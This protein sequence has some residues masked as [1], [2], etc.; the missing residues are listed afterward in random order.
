MAGEDQEL[1]AEGERRIEWAARNMPV[2]AEIARRWRR[3]RPL[4]GVR[5]GACLHVTT[6][7]A[8]LVLALAGGGAS[9]ALCASNPLSTQDDVAAALNGRL[10]VPTFARRGEDQDTYYRH[11]LAVLDT[12]P[13]LV[14]DDGA[15][16][17]S[18]LHTQRAEL[19]DGVWA[20][21]EE[22]TTGVLRLAAMER[23]GSLR[24][25]VVAVNQAQTKHMFDNRYG[26]GQSA[27][28]GVLRATNRL[29]AGSTLVVVGY[30]WCGRGVAARGRGLGARVVVVEVDP[31]KALEAVMDGFWVTDM[32]EAARLGDL[33]ITVTGNARVI[34]RE[35]LELMKD[36]A[37]LANAG[38]F[39]VEVDIP[40]LQ[41]LA[42]SRRPARENVEEFTL[43][44]GRRLYL[45]GEGRLV[46]L[47]CAEGHPAQVMDMSFANQALTLEWLAKDRPPLERRVLPVPA[48]IDA[49]VARLKLESLGVRLEELTPEQRAYLSSWKLGTTG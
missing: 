15:D 11:I 2:L 31:L 23:E 30:G 36:G 46:N 1:V 33:F 25:P 43:A 35:H 12:R 22:T 38:H 9:V 39:N 14:M 49:R 10:G 21:T 28:D 7:T 5:V 18:T 17:I 6:E 41:A 29:I 27:L 40:A 19:L 48:D 45:L 8:N 16:L 47:A 24:V 37:L 44:D 20:G 4:A 3:E 32:A 13:H 26:T 42:Q 34:R